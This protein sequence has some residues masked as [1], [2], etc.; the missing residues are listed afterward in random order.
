MDDLEKRD[1]EYFKQLTEF[2]MKNYLEKLQDAL[3]DQ[4]SDMKEVINQ[5][6]SMTTLQPIMMQ[7]LNVQTLTGIPTGV[8]QIAQDVTESKNEMVKDAQEAYAKAEAYYNELKAYYES[9]SDKISK[10]NVEDEISSIVENVQEEVTSL[11]K[12]TIDDLKEDLENFKNALKSCLDEFLDDLQD[13]WDEVQNLLKNGISLEN[14][15]FE[16][17]SY[18]PSEW[19]DEDDEEEEE[20][21]EEEEGFEFGDEEIEWQL[22]QYEQGDEIVFDDSELDWQKQE[23]EKEKKKKKKKK[24]KKEEA[25]STDDTEFDP[26]FDFSDEEDSDYDFSDDDDT[27]QT[28][29]NP[30]IRTFKGTKT[31]AKEAAGKGVEKALKKLAQ[32]L[33]KLAKGAGWVGVAI[34]ILD[35]EIQE[36][37]KELEKEGYTGDVK[38]FFREYLGDLVD[39]P[40]FESLLKAPPKNPKDLSEAL[41][42]GGAFVD[43]VSKWTEGDA[44]TMAK[45]GGQIISDAAAV[46]GDFL[47]GFVNSYN[48]NLVTPAVDSVG[49]FLGLEEDT[50]ETVHDV[51]NFVAGQVGGLAD[52]VVTGLGDA[53]G[54]VYDLGVV[55]VEQVGEL[56]SGL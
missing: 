12:D 54:S 26:A 56:I 38:E 28:T 45:E 11:V 41:D 19:D 15:S 36:V 50:M 51:H 55:G 13:L 4:Q 34:S 18:D 14:L 21:E 35:F 7:E 16:F 24:E 53:V 27:T 30:D 49:E 52:S 6:T 39:T 20:E 42:R 23:Y 44:A 25:P 9:L 10:I 46:G 2:K 43:K 33:P 40:E 37:L 1:F 5:A 3:K 47:S 32:K 29:Q 48:E 31:V 17:P 22:Q 8:M